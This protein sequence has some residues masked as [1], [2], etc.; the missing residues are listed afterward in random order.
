MVVSFILFF[1]HRGHSFCVET[2]AGD[3]SLSPGR[4]SA[5]LCESL[6]SELNNQ[7]SGTYMF[8]VQNGRGYY[9]KVC[10][11]EAQITHFM[12]TYTDGKGSWTCK[13][14]DN[15]CV[16]IVKDGIYRI[17]KSGNSYKV[18]TYQ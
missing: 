1:N 8:K 7:S 18:C 15:V 13:Q 4:M 10:N 11:N 12:E 2:N 9:G 14:S 3:G 5:G 16:S 17:N 6:L